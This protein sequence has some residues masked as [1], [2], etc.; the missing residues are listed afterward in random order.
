MTIAEIVDSRGITE[1]LHFTTHRGVTGI[2]A[3][4]VLRSRTALPQDEY[5]E[6]VRMNVCKDRSRDVQWHDYVNLS[7]TSINQRLFRIA[8]DNWHGSMPGW[9]CVVSFHPEILTHE[10]VW[11][12]TTNNMYSGVKRAQEADGLE[13]MFSQRN[14][15]YLTHFAQRN[16]DT[17]AN[18]PTCYQAEALYPCGIPIDYIQKFYLADDDT[19]IKLESIIDVTPDC[20]PIPCEVDAA[21]FTT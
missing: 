11:F 1:V 8:R 12:T 4:G 9:W 5:L 21:Y 10:G 17:P 20:K 14:H 13:L 15:Q 7:I 19:A 18:Q 2:L 16:A 6:F 3:S